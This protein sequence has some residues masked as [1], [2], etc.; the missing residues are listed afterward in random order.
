MPIRPVLRFAVAAMLALPPGLAR[1]AGDGCSPA[2]FKVALDVGHTL[3]QPGATS[4][5]GVPEFAYNQ[6][7]ARTVQA[8][9]AR[10]GIAT[11][12]I[13]EAGG[14]MP[15]LDRTRLAQGAGASLFL[16]LHHDSVQPQYLSTWMVDGRPLPYSDIFR[17][18]SVF[19]SGTGARP[20]ESLRFASLLGSGLRAAGFTPSL[21]HALPVPGEGRP[22]VDAGLGIFR[23]DGLAVLRTAAMPAAL[24]EAGIILNRDEEE[25][26]RSSGMP[27][28]MA[29]AVTGAIRRYCG[30][31][32]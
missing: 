31:L 7:L 6:R 9:L 26:I 14:P 20:A 15:L 29:A 11:A 2:R 24:L 17:G 32:G 8:A 18:Y 1:A 5:R 22:V 12:L 28:R 3:S 16:S 10:A 19:V 21:H 25:A 30:G 27:E 13:G 4:A 23:F